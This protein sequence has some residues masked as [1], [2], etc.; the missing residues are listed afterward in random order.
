LPVVHR[1]HRTSGD[2]EAKRYL[3]LG[4][5]GRTGIVFFGLGAD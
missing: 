3:D 5:G 2:Y 4:T 1:R